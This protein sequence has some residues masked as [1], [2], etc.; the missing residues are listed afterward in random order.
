[1]SCSITSGITLSCKD[2]QGGINYLYIADLPSYDTITTDVDGKITS[3]DASGSPVS[4]NWYKF[5]VPKQTS[6][7]T[8]VINAD[9]AAGTV[10][11]QQDV[12]M[13]F[14]KMQSTVRDQIKL[15]A[16]NPKLLVAVKDAND[17]FWIVGVTRG[18]EVSAGTVTSGTAYGDRNGGEITITGLEPE[19]MY[20]AVAAFVGE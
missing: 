11:Y 8:E 1:M 4:I 14:N 18:A 5:E 10:F 16:Q 17:L 20:E 2:S 13:V 7:V 12:L 15:L 3:L 6:S 9:N 19:P